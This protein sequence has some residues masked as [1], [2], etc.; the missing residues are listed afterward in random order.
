MKWHR[1]D[2]TPKRVKEILGDDGIGDEYAW[3][4]YLSYSFVDDDFPSLE[5]AIKESQRIAYANSPA[6]LAEDMHNSPYW[7]KYFKDLFAS[8]AWLQGLSN[9]HT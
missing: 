8:S 2:F 3:N 1:A 5:G 9:E 4:C 6:R 7:Q